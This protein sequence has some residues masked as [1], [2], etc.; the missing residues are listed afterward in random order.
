MDPWA[1]S[2]ELGHLPPPELSFENSFVQA[3]ETPSLSREEI[4]FEKLPDSDNYLQSLESKL[5]RL[6]G[7]RTSHSSVSRSRP[8]E[9][10]VLIQDLSNAREAA[11]AQ[12][13]NTI[14]DGVQ[15]AELDQVVDSNYLVRRLV[16]QQPVNVG[17]QVELTKA[18]QLEQKNQ[19]SSD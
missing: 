4:S 17:E 1:G 13:L 9:E 6:G 14:G 3:S 10:R 12:L 7:R 8:C 2:A 16:P 18:D 11:I 19:E 5:E 15:D